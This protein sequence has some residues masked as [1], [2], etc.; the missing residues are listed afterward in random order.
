MD[1]KYWSNPKYD[2]FSSDIQM[3]L[4]RDHTVAKYG[5]HTVDKYGH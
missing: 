1:I 4:Q 2:T 5:H 3:S